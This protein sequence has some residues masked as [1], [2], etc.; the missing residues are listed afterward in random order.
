[1]SL[2]LSVSPDC[3]SALGT[4]SSIVSSSSS[5]Q[6]SG[7]VVNRTGS[8]SGGAVVRGRC[9]LAEPSSPESDPEHPATSSTGTVARAITRAAT[10][11]RG[12]VR[13]SMVWLP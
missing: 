1:M 13:R 3:G 5:E 10:A 8:G 6:G 11:V 9:S 12:A 2:E 7:S 4:T